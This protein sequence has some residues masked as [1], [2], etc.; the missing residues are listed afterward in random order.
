VGA[1]FN[2]PNDCL[3]EKVLDLLCK[4]GQREDHF[5][6]VKWLPGEAVTI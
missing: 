2:Y 3:E 1:L 4:S 6:M 5:L